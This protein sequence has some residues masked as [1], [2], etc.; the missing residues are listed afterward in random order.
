MASFKGRVD[1]I[2][3]IHDIA[4][5]VPNARM[6][7]SDSSA[8]DITA[9]I[10]P[11]VAVERGAPSQAT[12]RLWEQW[13]SRPRKAELAR[14]ILEKDTGGVNF[15]WKLEWDI[16]PSEG[17]YTGR[18]PV[19][20]SIFRADGSLAS[21]DLYLCDW[22]QPPSPKD[23]PAIFSVLAIDDLLV[24]HDQQPAAEDI[25][26]VAKAA[27]ETA[28]PPAIVEAAGFRALPPLRRTIPSQLRTGIGE[29]QDLEVWGV[30]FTANSPAG[31][32]Q[33]DETSIVVWVNS[34][35]KTSKLS[36][37]HWTTD[38]EGRRRKEKDRGRRRKPTEGSE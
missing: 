13:Q 29:E 11:A 22:C 36:L 18:P 37:G 20:R 4:F 3:I 17:G 31:V 27:I 32:A 2:C 5:V 23:S 33:T 15:A 35:L 38:K 28:V 12:L 19:Y 7:E 1:D 24:A 14:A 30:R 25:I 21:P 10:A 8:A 6:Q 26:R 16:I 34:E 9:V